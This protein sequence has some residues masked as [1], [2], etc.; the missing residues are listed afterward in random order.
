MNLT[1]DTINKPHMKNQLFCLQPGNLSLEDLQKLIFNPIHIYLDQKTYQRIDESR[2][3]VQDVIDSEQSVYGINT[4]FGLLADQKI[5]KKDLKEL[6]KRLV[7]SHASGVGKPLESLVVKLIMLLKINSLAQGY[8]GITQNTLDTLIALYNHEI[9]PI[10]PEKGSVGASGDL[11]PLAHMSMA[12]IGEG[13]VNYNGQHISA[14]KALDQAGISIVTLQEKE[15]LALLNGTQ[16]STALAIMG[17]IKTMRNFSIATI[18]GSLSIDAVQA[19]I[20]PFHP[21]IAEI[22]KSKGQIIFSNVVR[23]LLDKSQLMEVHQ[24]SCQKVQDPYSLRCQPQVMGAIWQV[25][26][27]AKTHL[28]NEANG[29]SDN[30]LILTEEKEIISGGNF[31]AE[32]SAMSADMLSFACAEIGAIAERRIALLIDKNLSGLPAFLVNDAGLNSGFMLAHVTASALASENKTLAHPACVDSL[33]TSANQEDHVSMATFAGAKLNTICDNVLS[34][35]AIETLAACQ[36]ISLKAPLKSSPVLTQ[37]LQLIRD[38]VP[39][40]DQDRYFAKDI[41]TAT[42]IITNKIYYE[43]IQAKL[44]NHTDQ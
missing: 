6:Q 32:I 40:Y 20:K 22:K 23:D 15:G 37:K 27:N 1:I 36:G 4:G 16:V 9:Y 12:L 41:E 26:N 3:L 19:S 13:D 28:L 5:S 21:K 34:I 39:S 7:L 14:K 38:K 17:L 43:D 44:F 30:P 35:L 11:A 18:S 24:K 10:I 42:S 8:S 31:H 25:I 29:V 33:P 2:A